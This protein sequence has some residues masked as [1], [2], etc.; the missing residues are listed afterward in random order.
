MSLDCEIYAVN[1]NQISYTPRYTH[2]EYRD[3]FATAV[4]FRQI[5]KKKQIELIYLN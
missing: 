3:K 2:E 1:S 5:I 4:K